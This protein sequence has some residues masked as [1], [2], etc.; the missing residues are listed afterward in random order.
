M[1]S[2]TITISF[3]HVTFPARFQ[4]TETSL[5]VIACYYAIVR[6][7]SWRASSA[8]FPIVV[9]LAFCDAFARQKDAKS[10]YNNMVILRDETWI[11][12]WKDMKGWDVEIWPSYTHL[13]SPKPWIREDISWQWSCGFR[14]SLR[15]DLRIQLG[16]IGQSVQSDPGCCHFLTKHC[17]YEALLCCE[18]YL[19]LV[20]FWWNLLMAGRVRNLEACTY[21]SWH[22]VTTPTATG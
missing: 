8:R 4:N 2:H 14:N 20:V 10:A 21:G 1:K 15:T 12:G 6:D 5:T 13:P 17:G 9:G 16:S 11:K 7:P 22:K 19:H 18:L 3:C